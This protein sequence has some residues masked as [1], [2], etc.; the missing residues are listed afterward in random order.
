MLLT[1]TGLAVPSSARD[2]A[3][4]ATTADRGAFASGRV[5][6]SVGSNQIA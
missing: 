3:A 5:L 6:P 4:T 1:K 2:R